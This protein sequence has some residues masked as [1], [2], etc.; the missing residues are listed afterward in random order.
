LPGNE[1]LLFRDFMLPAVETKKLPVI[2]KYEASQQIPFDL[3]EV[4]WQSLYAGPLEIEGD[5]TLS[6]NILLAAVKNEC[7]ARSLSQFG[8]LQSRLDLLTIEQLIIAE[9]GRALLQGDETVVLLDMHAGRTQ[10]CLVNRGSVRCRDLPI[11]GDNFTRKLMTVSKMPFSTAEHLKKALVDSRDHKYILQE[12]HPE[13]K[14]LVGQIERSLKIWR[15]D[16]KSLTFS[17]LY[18]T[19]GPTKL[20]GLGPYL[21]ESLGL[22]VESLATVKPSDNDLGEAMSSECAAATVVALQR[23]GYGHFRTNFLP[24]A[25]GFGLKEKS[26]AWGIKLGNA[27]ISAV[28]VSLR[29]SKA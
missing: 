27:G 18:I 10:L 14:E 26:A 15:V 2:V 21:K 17:K 20:P 12:M 5:F 6:G 23:L 19:G 13:F 25:F 1:T 7:V 4:T 28:K 24:N 11:G 29:D 9:L 16:D 3:R 8:D 22:K